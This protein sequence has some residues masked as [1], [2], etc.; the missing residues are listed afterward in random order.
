MQEMNDV[1][2]AAEKRA[3]AMIAGDIDGIAALLDERLIYTHSSGVVDT[4][5]SYIAA[6]NRK[7]YIYHSVETVKTDYSL[8]D[9]DLVISN[10]V[11]AVSMTVRSSGQTVSRQIRVTEIWTR[12][13]GDR[14]WRLLV[15]HSTNIS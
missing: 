12:G 3:A 9:G 15:S 14:A 5:E 10:K 2:A 1:N 11:M 7:E 13:N 6:L 8:T 4:R